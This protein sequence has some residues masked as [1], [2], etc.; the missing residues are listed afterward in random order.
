MDPSGPD[1]DPFGELIRPGAMEGRVKEEQERISRD[2]VDSFHRMARKKRI[3]LK[4][5]LGLF[6]MKDKREVG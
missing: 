3:P 1:S 5:V 2:I 4:P 6:I